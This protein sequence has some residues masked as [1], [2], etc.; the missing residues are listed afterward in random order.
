MEG[1]GEVIGVRQ[2]EISE[3][4]RQLRGYYDAL[5]AS[6]AALEEEVPMYR[7]VF[8]PVNLFFGL[9]PYYFVFDS[10][11]M[12]A[13]HAIRDTLKFCEVELKEWSKRMGNDKRLN[14]DSPIDDLEETE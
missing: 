2:G 4:R 7:A 10:Y 9:S 14:V 11:E 1:A 12:K 13:P 5:K 6:E 8:D 3:V